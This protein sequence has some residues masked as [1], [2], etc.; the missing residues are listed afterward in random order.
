MARRKLCENDAV[1]ILASQTLDAAQ[2]RRALAVFGIEATLLSA[3]V[4]AKLWR[5]AVLDGDTGAAKFLLSNL[6]GENW[7][8]RSRRPKADPPAPPPS[9]TDPPAD[10]DPL[11]T[12]RLIG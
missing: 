7:T 12:L 2:V 10:D 3:P 6:D 1:K 4:I 11:K 5:N 9:A 8:T